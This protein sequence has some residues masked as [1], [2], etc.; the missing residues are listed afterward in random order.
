MS[1]GKHTPLTH[2][3]R[4]RIRQLRIER[5]LTQVELCKIAGI[6]SDSITRIESG[7]RVPTLDTLE[8]I[9]QVFDMPVSILVGNDEPPKIK[10]QPSL[11]RIVYLL[12]KYSPEVHEACEKLL[13]SALKGF[14]TSEIAAEVLKETLD[15]PRKG[16]AKK[17]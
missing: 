15:T 6:S 5:D 12:R 10:H 4:H 1:R 7:S 9:A 3:V 17:R 14:L 13:K 11:M 16:H 2:M 8:K